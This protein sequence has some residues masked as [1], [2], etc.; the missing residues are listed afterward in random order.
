VTTALEVHDGPHAAATRAASY[1]AERARE[2]VPGSG[3]FT[4]A[5][6]RSQPLV[7]RLGDE[8]VP[9]PQ[10]LVYQ[11][12][13]RVAPRGHEHRN[14]EQ[15]LAALP[16]ESL[17]PMPVDAADL[18][19]SAAAYADELPQRLDL[20]HLGLGTDGHT[21]SLLP[22]DPVLDARDGLVAVTGEHQGRRRMTLTYPALEAAGEIV[23]LVTGEAKHDVLARL[24]AGDRSMPA[25]RVANARQLIVC[26]RAAAS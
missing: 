11:A 18:E 15:L 10:T 1:I 12:D 26:D 22:G 20:V 3:R 25:G 2:T 13:E 24:L 19:A 9:W 16:H 7:E 14:L 6:S 23:W 4:L 17:R 21:A 5:L 8:D